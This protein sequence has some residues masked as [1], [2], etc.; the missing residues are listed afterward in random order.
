MIIAN[1]SKKQM[2]VC[3]NCF[4]KKTW[5]EWKKLSVEKDKHEKV[6]EDPTAPYGR[7]AYGDP[8]PAPN[9]SKRSSIFGCMADH[10]E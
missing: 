9:I 3:D 1:I 6:E 4:S 8:L 10:A 2:R 5:I 7:D